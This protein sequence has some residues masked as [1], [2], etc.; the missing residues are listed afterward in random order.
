MLLDW[1]RLGLGLGLLQKKLDAFH[2]NDYIIYRRV[3][4]L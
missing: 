2:M 3:L 4:E 1:C